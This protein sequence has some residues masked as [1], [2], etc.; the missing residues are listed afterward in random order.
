MSEAST[1]EASRAGVAMT[2]PSSARMASH[3]EWPVQ[4]VLPRMHERK[5]W[6]EWPRATL[7]ETRSAPASSPS[8]AT[9]KSVM[10]VSAPFVIRRSRTTRRARAPST[11]L[12]VRVVSS[13]PDSCTVSISK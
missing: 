11:A 1:C 5:V 7:R 9:S 13:T 4:R 6:R 10:A 3:S 2:Q 12:V 8:R